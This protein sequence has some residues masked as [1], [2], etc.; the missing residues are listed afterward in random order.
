MTVSAVHQRLHDEHGLAV[1]LEG[2]R[3]F[4]AVSLPEQLLAE[5]VT[6]L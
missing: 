4:I 6:E 1:S 2:L 3:R 5:Q